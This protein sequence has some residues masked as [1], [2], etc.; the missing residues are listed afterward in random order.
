[1]RNMLV[2]A[3][4]SI[5]YSLWDLKDH[6]VRLRTWQ[7]LEASQWES[8]QALLNRQ[9]AGLQKIMTYAYEKCPYYRR[10]F[11][12]ARVSPN[13][14]KA[15][16]DLLKV[17][18]LTKRHIQDYTDQMTSSDFSTGELLWAK[19]G[20]STGKAVKVFV[21]KECVERREAAALRSNQWANWF[22]GDRVGALWGNPPQF[23]SVK[24]RIRQAL[25]EK[26]IFLDTVNLTRDSMMTFVEKWTK[27]RARVLF[28]H[29]HSLYRF[30]RFLEDNKIVEIRP[31]GIVSTSMMLLPSERDVIERV[32][33][34][35][36]TDRY[37]SEEVG[38][39]ACECERHSGMHLNVERLYVEFIK[40]DGTRARPG[41]EGRIVVTDLMNKGMPLIRY[42]IEDVGIAS[43]RT[44]PCGRGLPLM[45]RVTGRTADFLVKPNGAL[46][47]GVSLIERT[48]TAI[49]GI[50]QMQIIQE[51]LHRIEINLV[52]G[53]DY[54]MCSEERLR[55]EFALVFGSEV[56]CVI[57]HVSRI[58]QERSGK[59]RFSICSVPLNELGHSL[60][61]S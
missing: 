5:I 60:I 27:Y 30:A 57:H 46:V 31:K 19:T 36:V 61:H 18:I 41:E 54:T 48:L 28:G 20:G 2:R 34:C 49:P 11:D 16:D 4:A 33:A 45:E 51:D 1:M 59:Y 25:H 21:D 40:D 44:C 53:R 37:G 43:D 22:I 29:A 42:K 47:A 32:F 24:E 15:P 35:K 38:L 26:V 55:Q 58:K 8:E 39:I 13:D 9:W 3:W 52:T 23:T 17:P 7:E 14:I 6:S 12:K 50:E 10:Q 56:K